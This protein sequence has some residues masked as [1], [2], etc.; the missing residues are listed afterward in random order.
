MVAFR[1]LSK[2]NPSCVTV[3]A[4]KWAVVQTTL[5][6]LAVGNPAPV[7]RV[8]YFAAF[9][10]KLFSC[11]ALTLAYVLN[12]IALIENPGGPGGDAAGG[13]EMRAVSASDLFWY[14]TIAW[15]TANQPVREIPS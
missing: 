5:R 14:G 2:V 12:S 8:P 3:E 7:R 4:S 10:S 1:M 11:T 6:L 13:C 9:Q 15:S